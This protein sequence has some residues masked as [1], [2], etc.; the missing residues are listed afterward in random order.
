M[1]GVVN[2]PILE[3]SLDVVSDWDDIDNAFEYEE[4]EKLLLV[5]NNLVPWG[6]EE[7]VDTE[8]PMPRSDD[9]AFL[10]KELDVD[11]RV[12]KVLKKQPC[13]TS[14]TRFYIFECVL[15]LPWQF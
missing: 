1:K 8:E 15:K 4:R 9:A 12:L 10:S 7:Y 11:C 5:F 2:F 13:T 3:V 14:S 6:D